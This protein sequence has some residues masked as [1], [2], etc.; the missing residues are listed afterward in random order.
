MR[1]RLKNFA[2]ILVD[3]IY[4]RRCAICDRTIKGR[5]GIC[6]SCEKEIQYLEG[7]LCMKCGKR[8]SDEGIRFCYDCRST[9]KKYERGFAI[10]EYEYIKDSLFRFKYSGRAEYSSFY[11]QKAYERLGDVLYRLGIEAFIPVPIHKKRYRKRGYNQAQE[12]A[13]ELSRLTGIAV[14]G[15][16]VMRDENTVPLKKLSAVERQKNLKKAF[17]LT[18]N[19]V[20]FSKVC[21]VD[22]IYTTG[23]TID[24][25]ST[26]LKRHGVREVY[27]VSVAIGKGV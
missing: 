19:D 26:L 21:I 4:P 6:Q 2:D 16:L 13:I 3:A 5:K 20:K 27:F 7:A 22:D 11:A 18:R 25:I 12:L 23:A 15:S 17:K 14:E 8:V 10:F 1:D 9:I 24:A